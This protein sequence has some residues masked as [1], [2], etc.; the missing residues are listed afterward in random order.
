MKEE[1]ISHS[2]KPV[3]NFCHRRLPPPLGAAVA[4]SKSSRVSQSLA[5]FFCSPR[6]QPNFATPQAAH[7]EVDTFAP[8]FGVSALK[9]AAEFLHQ[10]HGGV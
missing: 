3:S 7:D 9:S 8:W 10:A 4:K 1:V 5:P 2:Q 6:E